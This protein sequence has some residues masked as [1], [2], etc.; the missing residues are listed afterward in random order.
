METWKF[1]IPEVMPETNARPPARMIGR[2]V[3]A[4][5]DER[6]KKLRFVIDMPDDP[7]DQEKG[8]FKWMTLEFAGEAGLDTSSAKLEFPQIE[9]ADFLK[10][11][12]DGTEATE[13][14]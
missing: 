12:D 11:H 3:F 7:T 9:W 13:R 2:T 8:F 4:V 14:P 6:D 5:I 1:V 10:E